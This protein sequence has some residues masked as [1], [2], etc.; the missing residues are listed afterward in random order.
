MS[1]EE[2]LVLDNIF[3][4][5]GAVSILEGVYMKALPARVCGLFGRGGSGK[6]TI[7]KVAA[8]QIRALS[9]ATIIDGRRFMEPSRYARF[10]RIAYLPQDPMLPDHYKVGSLVHAFP[11]SVHR[12]LE[13]PVL[14]KLKTQRVGQ[15]SGGERRYLELQIVL[16]LGRRYVLLDE[17]FTGIAPLLVEQMVCAIEGAAESG[18][19]IVIADHDYRSLLQ[20]VQDAYIVRNKQCRAIKAG[21]EL[22]RN[23][24]SNGYLC[25]GGSSV[26]SLAAS[27]RQLQV[28]SAH[29]SPEPPEPSV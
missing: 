22:A 17:P 1:L 16:N 10:Q 11:E 13:N 25:P 23:L 3:Y 21:A 14:S 2:A 20:I 6:S 9:G 24:E 29:G 27:G 7:L 5:H 12:A 26:V 28:I 4:A 18:V 15:L 19:G 8:G